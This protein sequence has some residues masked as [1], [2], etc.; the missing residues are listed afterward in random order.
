VTV[1]SQFTHLPKKSGGASRQTH[2][3]EIIEQGQ[4]IFSRAVRQAL[5]LVIKTQA[6]YWHARNPVFFSI[7]QSGE[8]LL[9]LLELERWSG[10]KNK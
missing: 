8:I 6:S 7:C 2:A 4:P 1:R 3:A 9:R 5:T 10:S